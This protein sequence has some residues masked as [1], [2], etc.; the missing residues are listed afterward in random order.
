MKN[1]SVPSR[2]ELQKSYERLQLGQQ[3]VTAEQLVLWSQWSRL[4]PRLAQILVEYLQLKF[5][6]INPMDV[7]STNSGTPLPQA[8]P[9][10]C[11]FV[12]LR[13]RK[14]PTFAKAFSAWCRTCF[15]DLPAAPPQLFFIPEGVPNERRSFTEIGETL[16]P[17]AKWGFFSNEW[18]AEEKEVL[19]HPK[20]TLMNAHSRQDCLKDL[21][22]KKSVVTVSDYIQACSGR[23]HRR[24]AER[25]LKS[26]P[27]VSARGFTRNLIYK[28][29]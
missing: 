23:I 19:T 24:M 3:T 16:R 14:K 13:L 17:F 25:D 6:N 18:I 9:V 22:K 12:A 21:L 1:V 20:A 4:D 8:L 11:E 29:V 2:E 26:S 5:Q 27:L 28:K 15:G 10:L 7:W